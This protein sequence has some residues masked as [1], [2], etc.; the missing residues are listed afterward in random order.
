MYNQE[1]LQYEYFIN[2]NQNAMKKNITEEM[3]DRN[4]IAIDNLLSKGL[5]EK[6]IEILRTISEHKRA[7]LSTVREFPECDFKYTAIIDDLDPEFIKYYCKLNDKYLYTPS[8]LVKFYWTYIEV[9][10]E[11]LIIELRSRKV[12]VQ[13]TYE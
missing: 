9:V 3:K 1:F 12:K 11:K 4:T 13:I 8:D 2:K 10:S 5:K 7:Y 6:E